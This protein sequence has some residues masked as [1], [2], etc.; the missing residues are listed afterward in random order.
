M[1]VD[2]CIKLKIKALFNESLAIIKHS[3]RVSG[4]LAMGCLSLD[5]SIV[6]HTSEP[7][8]RGMHLIHLANPLMGSG[9]KA[10]LLS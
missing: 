10:I 2:F 6:T 1:D 5:F 4:E 9:L 7:R 8:V 3:T